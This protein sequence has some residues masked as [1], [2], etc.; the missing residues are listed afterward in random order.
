M[1]IC[2]MLSLMFIRRVISLSVAKTPCYACCCGAMPWF[3]WTSQPNSR[4]SAQQSGLRPR[5]KAVGR[6][7]RANGMK[8]L[9]ISWNQIHIS[10][11]HIYIYIHIYIYTYI[12]NKKYIKIAK[13]GC[14][15]QAKRLQRGSTDAD[16]A[17]KMSHLDCKE[18]VSLVA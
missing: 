7:N 8:R 9:W 1:H 2:S 11:T 6:S 15:W 17:G 14:W 3:R 12:S 13:D 16:E 18:G 4:H 5:P 10:H